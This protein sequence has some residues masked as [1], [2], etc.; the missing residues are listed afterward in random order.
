MVNQ[1]ILFNECHLRD[2]MKQYLDYYNT[3]RCHISVE[4]ESP[5]GRRIEKKPSE[6]AKIIAFPKL[7]GLHHVYKWDKVA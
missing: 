3:E 6:S 1:L 2:F 4:R 5:N 7:G